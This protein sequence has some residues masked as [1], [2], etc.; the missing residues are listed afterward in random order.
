MALA[1][2][3]GNLLGRLSLSFVTYILLVALPAERLGVLDGVGAAGVE[4][5]PRHCEPAFPA[6][7]SMLDVRESPMAA[8]CMVVAIAL[9]FAPTLSE[10]PAASHRLQGKWPLHRCPRMTNGRLINDQCQWGVSH[11]L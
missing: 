10:D 9:A 11:W 6:Q 1:V 4:R 8:A 2:F 7:Q 3:S 5:R